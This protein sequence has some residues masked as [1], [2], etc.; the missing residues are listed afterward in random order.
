MRTAPNHTIE[1]QSLHPTIARAY[2]KWLLNALAAAVGRSNSPAIIS[3][4]RTQAI[5]Q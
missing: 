1:S 4:N 3:A 2:S 5:G